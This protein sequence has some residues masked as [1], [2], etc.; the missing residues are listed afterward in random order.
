M[1]SKR[2][3]SYTASS[4]INQPASANDP[5]VKHLNIFIQV[6]KQKAER[7][8]L[9]EF[10]DMADAKNQNTRNRKLMQGGREAGELIFS[11]D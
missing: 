3:A 8:L 5:R 6:A 9:K 11:V 1:G 10:P 7:Q 4:E 2:Y